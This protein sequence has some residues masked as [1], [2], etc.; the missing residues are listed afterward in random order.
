M[1]GVLCG[2]Q[3]AY[4]VGWTTF[5]SLLAWYKVLYGAH[6][7]LEMQTVYL[8]PSI[9]ILLLQQYYDNYIDNLVGRAT[10]TAFRMALGA[11][12]RLPYPVP[13]LASS[14]DACTQFVCALVSFA[15][16]SV[17]VCD[18]VPGTGV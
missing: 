5:S 9:P 11:P 12:A 1:R 6:I 2:T 18:A 17:R 14:V 10:A 13:S 16:L 15:W 7:L 3:V 8:L 4:T